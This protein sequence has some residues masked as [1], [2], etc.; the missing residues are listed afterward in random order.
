[1][2]LRI[3]LLWVAAAAANLAIVVLAPP[4]P[5][6]AGPSPAL[7]EYAQR[8]ADEERPAVLGAL[9]Q[10]ALLAAAVASAA[11]AV[12][13]LDRLDAA[14]GQAIPATIGAALGFGVAFFVALQLV[15][16]IFVGIPDFAIEML[17]EGV[18]VGRLERAFLIAWLVAV[19]GAPLG[20]A[21]LHGG[22]PLDLRSLARAQLVAGV[23]SVASVAVASW[24]RQLVLPPRPDILFPGLVT[25][26]AS[27]AGWLRARTRAEPVAADMR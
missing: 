9:A 12:R 3:T 27:V 15:L 4:P 22:R 6:P 13:R 20:A 25:I 10:L 2:K 24:A 23:A 21:L 19:G 5:P 16:L 26:A 1:M 8:R 11:L 17:D 7:A 18:I 14:P